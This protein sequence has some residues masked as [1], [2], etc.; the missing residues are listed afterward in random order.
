[1]SPSASSPAPALS[2]IELWRTDRSRSRLSMR[3]G[4]WRASK[5]WMS[6]SV[7]ARVPTKAASRAPD[8]TRSM[9]S[10]SNAGVAWRPHPDVETDEGARCL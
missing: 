3:K 8:R 9:M 6:Y 5:S 2:R 10:C 1:M 4:A 7:Q